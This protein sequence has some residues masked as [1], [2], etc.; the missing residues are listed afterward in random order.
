MPCEASGPL[1]GVK[2]LEFGGI[3]PAPFAGMVLAGL[4]ADVL[5]LGRPGDNGPPELPGAD[6]DERWRPTLSLDL[7]DPQGRAVALRLADVADAV[8][9][10]FRPG[11]MERLGLGPEVLLT[12]NPRIVYGRVTGYGQDGPLAA[13][14]GH[15]INYLALSGV[16]G[17]ISRS[18]ERPLFPL[19]L[20]ADYGGGG[21]LLALGVV[22]AVLDAQRSGAGQVIDAAMV[23]GVAQLATL[24]YGLDAAGSWGPPGTNLLDSGAPFYEVYE[25]ADGGHM[26]VGAIE[27]RFYAEL[28]RLL[29]IEPDQAPQWDR[30]RWPELKQRFGDLFRSRD[31]AYWTGIFE[32]AEACT[33]PVL[34]FQEAI[35]HRHN[36]ARGTFAGEPALPRPAPRFS[37]T[38]DRVRS[39]VPD[40]SATLR[41]W[42][43]A[44]VDA[45]PGS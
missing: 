30:T 25:T 22:A 34:S 8:I 15:D 13:V 21:M 5:R 43:I 23:E 2:V 39:E 32:T 10:G 14:A 44:D 7:K 9:E 1:A 35:E 11:V 29:A 38:P 17:A 37:L 42:G 26:A 45:A 36:R 31:R 20:L 33:S 41:R 19:N 12:R 28:L 6:A 24:F 27:P 16:L 3:G 18:G 4:G 40:L